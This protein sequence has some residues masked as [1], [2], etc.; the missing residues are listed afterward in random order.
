[1]FKKPI[2]NFG[3]L[4]LFILTMPE[5]FIAQLDYDI[6]CFSLRRIRAIN[7]L[8]FVGLGRMGLGM[9]QRIA[10]AGIRVV[11]FD[12][13]DSA[14]NAFTQTGK[15]SAVSL[16]E[17]VSKMT[18]RKTVWLMVP[19]GKAVDDSIAEIIDLLKPGDIIIDG[20][21]S[22]YQD[23]LRRYQALKEKGIYY[24]D[25]GTSG[26]WR[27]AEGEGMCL[28][29]GAD[30]EVYKLVE[31]LFR[32]LAW[33]DS[34]GNPVGYGR[35]GPPGAGHFVKTTI[36]NGAVEYSFFQGLAEGLTILA[37]SLGWDISVLKDVMQEVS[38]NPTSPLRSWAASLAYELFS[39][40]EQFESIGPQVE[41]GTYGVWAQEAARAFGVATPVLETAIEARKN[42]QGMLSLDP[43]AFTARILAGIR[44]YMG[45]HQYQQLAEPVT[46]TDLLSNL[47][48][49]EGVIT[50]TP[51]EFTD[52]V[53]TTIAFVWLAALREGYELMFNSPFNFSAQDLSQINH[54]WANGGVVRSYPV[55]LA[56]QYF[57]QGLSLEE[58]LRRMSADL[59]IDISVV[60]E[61]QEIAQNLGI[62]TPALDAALDKQ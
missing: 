31:P 8:T 34:E 16:R 12:L 39:N 62:P 22:N 58:T 2:K 46:Q 55:E 36:H 14:R 7:E 57:S 54:V 4:S 15:E 37:K 3:L 29:V 43:A 45:G 20:G 40:E 50:D 17:A 52:K 51:Q 13:N 10:A 26:G 5:V 23:S 30:E 32:A 28:M 59:G 61:V 47:G 6:D 35:V 11:G 33:K 38:S 24:V 9:A 41:G 27:A 25:C 53:I 1:M 49:A 42:S 18:G 44:Y 48:S 21:N 60:R 19:A 56:A